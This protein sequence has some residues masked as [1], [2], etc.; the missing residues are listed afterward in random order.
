MRVGWEVWEGLKQRRLQLGS[1]QVGQNG[2]E[3]AVSPGEGLVGLVGSVGCDLEWEKEGLG[4][5]GADHEWIGNGGQ[6]HV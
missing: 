3:K 5:R 4:W 1:C 6:H 2:C